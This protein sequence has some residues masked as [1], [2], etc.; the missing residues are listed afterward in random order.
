[1]IAFPHQTVSQGEQLPMD[2]GCVFP[3]G[4][5]GRDVRVRLMTA[6][7]D[8]AV[9]CGAKLR[10]WGLPHRPEIIGK[11]RT[12][13]TFAFDLMGKGEP[14]AAIPADDLR[15]KIFAGQPVVPRWIKFGGCLV[16]LETTEREEIAAFARWF[17]VV[18]RREVHYKKPKPPSIADRADAGEIETFDAREM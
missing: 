14:M 11:P 3:H 17:D 7:P 1:M 12:R 5:G 6:D 2:T 13:A 18:A 9:A 4:K 8:D 16:M 15:R 10:E